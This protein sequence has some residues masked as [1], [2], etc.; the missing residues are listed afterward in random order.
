L[1]PLTQRQYQDIGRRCRTAMRESARSNGGRPDP[2]DNPFVEDLSHALNDGH[3]QPG[4][5]SFRKL[6]EAIV[7]DGRAVIESWDP[8]N[9]GSSYRARLYGNDG[10]RLQE[11]TVT[12]QTFAKLTGQITYTEVLPVFER[13]SFYAS[14]IARTMQSGFEWEK[15]PEVSIPGD[16]AQSIPEN[17]DFPKVGLAEGFVQSQ[18]SEKH[19]AILEISKEALFFDRTGVILDR[20]RQLA[21]AL[22]I[23]KEKR[24]LDVATG[25]VTVYNRNGVSIATYGDNSGNHDWDN[26]QASNAL[27]DWTDIENVKKLFDAITDPNTG[28]P[29]AIDL[30]GMALLV[31]TALEWTAR[32]IVNA[33]EVEHVDNQANAD[34]IRTRSNNPVPRL[35]VF[36]NQYVKDRTSSDTTW[37]LGDWQNAVRYRENWP[38]QT[39]EDAVSPHDEIHRDVAAGIKISERGSAEMVEP[40]KVAK[41][42][43]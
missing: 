22:A 34:T 42:T 9:R 38:F 13:P 28:D 18:I 30:T 3:I 5:I 35:E 33:T 20:A 12:T 2:R 26:L 17:Q 43:A 25:Q 14:R 15:L 41:S 6:F 21:L 32:R 39:E 24:V 11:A 10:T 40:R 27:V 16:V 36:S 29:I 8:Q 31:P 37:F 23:D 1:K 4:E 7:P 19:G